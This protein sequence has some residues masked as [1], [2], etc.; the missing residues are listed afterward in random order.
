MPQAFDNCVKNGGRVRRVS[1]PNKKNGLAKGEYVNYCFLDGKSHR[2]YVKKMM[3][4]SDG[5]M[6]VKK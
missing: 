3:Q 6:I 1:G 2:G 5:Q 4:T